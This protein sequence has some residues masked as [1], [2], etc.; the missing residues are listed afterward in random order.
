MIK[1]MVLFIRRWRRRKIEISY[2]IE[3][4]SIKFLIF[5]L[6]NLEKNRIVAIEVLNKLAHVIGK[7]KTLSY[8][9]PL[10]DR[11]KSDPYYAVRAAI[12]MNLGLFLH[13]LSLL[14][15]SYHQLLFSVLFL[16]FTFLLC[17][18]SFLIFL[19]SICDV[20][21]DLTGVRI[22]PIFQHL[23]KDEI[24]IVRKACVDAIVVLSQFLKKREQVCTK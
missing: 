16:S 14:P 21:G 6:I 11:L 5:F 8:S 1:L 20:I 10:L 19:E 12:P 15:F 18:S 4:F 17:A 7:D 9:I 23:A 13:F 2:K 24:W 22:F 3:F